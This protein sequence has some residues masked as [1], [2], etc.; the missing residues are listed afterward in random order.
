MQI[1]VSVT[2]A[3]LLKIG[4]KDLKKIFGD[5]VAKVGGYVDL[6]VDAVLEPYVQLPTSAGGHGA[7]GVQGGV[8]VNLNLTPAL[9][10]LLGDK[11]SWDAAIFGQIAGQEQF[12]NGSEPGKARCRG[13][14]V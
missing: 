13:C 8:T 14:S 2:R 4:Q 5:K 9:K 6:S 10:K 12:D 11:T 3:D 7:A 1:F